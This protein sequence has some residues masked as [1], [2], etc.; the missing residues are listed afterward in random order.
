MVSTDQKDPGLSR[1]WGYFV[2]ENEYKRY[3]SNNGETLQEVRYIS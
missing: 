2:E 1:G 3:L